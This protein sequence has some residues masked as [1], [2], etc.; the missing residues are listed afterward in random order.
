MIA[1]YVAAVT[2][3]PA[4]A[5]LMKTGKTKL[6]MP[7]FAILILYAAGCAGIPEPLPLTTLKSSPAP[8]KFIPPD[9]GWNTVASL[10]FTVRGRNIPL[11]CNAELDPGKRKIAMVALNPDGNMKVF[12][13]AAGNGVITHQEMTPQL[14]QLPD[15]PKDV[16]RDMGRIS[17]DL[18]PTAEYRKS[19]K[20][21]VISFTNNGLTLNYDAQ[22]G[23]LIEKIYIKNEQCLWKID[24]R[25]Y[26][27]EKGFSVPCQIRLINF[28][29]DYSIMIKVKEFTLIEQKDNM[30]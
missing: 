11:L 20:D 2:M 5:A 17:F 27:L 24:F 19:Y 15:L 21:N 14:K 18:L 16:I 28:N 30:K 4:L 22:S 25:E 8:E 23:L 29:P 7:L 9:T 26:K 10:V 12:S 3:I 13:V 1:A 6:L